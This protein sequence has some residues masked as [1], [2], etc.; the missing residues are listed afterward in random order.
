MTEEAAASEEAL[1]DRRP[2]RGSREAL[3][4]RYDLAIVDLDGTVYVGREP[5][6]GA[7]DVL[8]RLAGGPM[9]VAFVTNNAARTPEQVARTL[10]KLGV[11]AGPEDVTTSAQAAAAVLRTMLPQ[12]STVLVVGGRGLVEA[13]SAQG[14]AV[15]TSAAD[16]P[17]A[18]VQGWT[19]ELDWRMLA[20][21]AYALA[22][23]VPWVATNT[24]LTVPTPRG[25]A[26]GNGSFVAL[27]G[28]A[29]G[30]TPDVVAGKPGV[31]LLEQTVFRYRARRVLVVGDR[32]DTDIAGADA[33]DLDSLLVL[34]GVSSAVDLTNA[35]PGSRPTY[36]GYD[37]RALLEPQPTVRHQGA[38][39]LSR[40]VAVSVRL[41]E[42]LAVVDPVTP[43]PVTPADGLDLVRTTST[44]IWEASDEGRTVHRSQKLMG[45]LADVRP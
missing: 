15:V 12:G 40:D 20:E 25:I 22:T 31:A 5:V 27:L 42:G 35:P 8:H 1:R 30:R 10:T 14:F 36:V 7:V 11:D 28:N 3:R 41:P 16:A 44:A 34:S 43:A 13:L 9:R 17:Q 45:W 19:P 29:T 32:L 4:D 21:G 18:V 26:P 33:A 2:L 37:L 38:R 23:G 24:D 39:Y 6:P